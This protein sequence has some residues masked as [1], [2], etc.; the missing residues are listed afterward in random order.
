MGLT[1]TW[2]TP[3]S[4]FGMDN[5][6]QALELTSQQL[7]DTFNITLREIQWWCERGLLRPLIQNNIRHF[8]S[9]ECRR[10]QRIKQLRK[11]GVSLTSIRRVLKSGLVYSRVIR[12]RKPTIIG[13]TLVVP[14]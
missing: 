14:Q 4:V 8:D 5:T 11:A 13:D 1:S 12:I 6:P 7:S 9:D 2:D 10:A 3:H